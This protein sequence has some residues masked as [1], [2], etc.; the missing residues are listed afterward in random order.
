ME[1]QNALALL[2]AVDQMFQFDLSA[3]GADSR[4]VDFGDVLVARRSFTSSL[5]S[6]VQGR[7]SKRTA[8]G[9]L[10]SDHRSAAAAWWLHSS[11]RSV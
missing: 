10:L 8:S 1:L 2:D 6:I 11:T 7:R 3:V 5:A 9:E 4:E